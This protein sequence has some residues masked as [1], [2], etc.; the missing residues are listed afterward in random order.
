MQQSQIDIIGEYANT[1]F[2][3]KV[4]AG[5]VPIHASLDPDMRRLLPFFAKPGSIKE[6]GDID[7]TITTDQYHY[8]WKKQKEYTISCGPMHFGHFKASIYN[9]TLLE[10]FDRSILELS[11]RTGHILPRW[12]NATD[13]MI[14]KKTDSIRVD[15][16]RTI[17]LLASDWNFGNKLLSKRLM[18]HSEKAN[19]IAPEQ[20]GSRKK[21]SAIQHATN[22]A[23][24]FDIQ[25]QR[26]QKTALL[27]LDAKACYDRIPIHIAALG[28]KRQG[29]PD[30]AIQ[31]MMS[32]IIKRTKH[33]VRTIYGDSTMKYSA[34][35]CKG[36]HGILQGN[37]AGPCIW[38][39]VS[40][41]LLDHLRDTGHGVPIVDH[42]TGEERNIPAIS[43]V[44]DNDLIEKLGRF[45]DISKTQASF[46]TWNTD[47]TA[48]SGALQEKKCSMQTLEYE[49]SNNNRWKLKK[50]IDQD[51]AVCI[52]TK[53]GRVRIVRKEHNVSTLALGIMF[54][55]DG[56]MTDQ[57]KFMRKKSATWSDELS[58]QQ[59]S[60]AEVSYAL[61]ASIMRTLQY[62][63]LATTLSRKEVDSIMAPI[64]NIALPRMGICRNIDRDTLYCSTAYKGF[65]LDNLWECQGIEKLLALLGRD[66]ET[67]TLILLQESLSLCKFE[68]GLGPNFLQ[69]PFC[70]KL[71]ATTTPGFVTTVWQFCSDSNILLHSNEKERHHYHDDTYL[72]KEWIGQVDDLGILRDLNICRKYLQVETLSD[73]LELNGRTIRHTAWNGETTS[74]EDSWPRQPRPTEQAWNHWRRWVANIIACNTEGYLTNPFNLEYFDQSNWMW[75]LSNDQ[76]LQLFKATTGKGYEVYQAPDTPLRRRQAQTFLA[77]GIFVQTTPPRTFAAQVSHI[78]IRRVEI[79]S[80]TRAFHHDLSIAK[81]PQWK[82][83]IR[84]K[85]V[86]NM[87]Q[88]KEGFQHEEIVLVS[89]GSLKEDYAAAAYIL[90]TI[91]MYQQNYLQGRVR[92]T[93][94]PEDQDSYRAELTGILAGLYHV[95]QLI[96][97]WELQDTH[98][99]TSRL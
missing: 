16:L 25:R 70:K 94:R 24:L 64:C 72:M 33:N 52:D 61:R 50:L 85:Q 91:S 51:E 37:G 92:T 80:Y 82:D 28:L 71:K 73:L 36:Y 11:L 30:S 79:Q 27:V 12:T 3:E 89:D 26:K 43:F 97:K 13:V 76:L 88:L 86:G 8:G 21:K 74:F 29:L 53:D 39:M 59:F 60:K 19:S 35:D 54:T 42:N 87:N 32:P 15:Q 4:L 20:Y 31:F 67:D 34:L 14:P 22:K 68:S 55:V 49:F 99:T 96:D 65:G 9:S 38:V 45:N 57:V 95:Q 47:L 40:S 69:V 2:T 56:T 84:M 90:T 7:L 93:G 5:D 1:A 63:L 62:P 41:P 46:D 78:S 98:D 23:I 83:S 48:I 66:Q 77:T 75:L 10:E 6:A 44:D 58:K 18:H 17:C 81:L